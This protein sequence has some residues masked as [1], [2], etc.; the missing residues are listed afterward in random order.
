M[1]TKKVENKIKFL[2]YNN[3]KY[4][5]IQQKNIHMKSNSYIIY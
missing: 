3:K 1:Q 4:I 2:K 5:Y